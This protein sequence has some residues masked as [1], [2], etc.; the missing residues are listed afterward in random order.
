[1][2]RKLSTFIAL[3][4]L[5]AFAEGQGRGA[6]GNNDD[7]AK[8]SCEP[9]RCKKACEFGYRVENGCEVCA[10]KSSPM[11][12]DVTNCPA[13]DVCDNQC[14]HGFMLDEQGCTTCKCKTACPPICRMACRHGFEKDENGCDICTC[15][16]SAFNRT[17]H[18]GERQWNKTHHHN[19]NNGNKDHHRSKMGHRGEH[20]TRPSHSKPR[21]QDRN[22][23]HN[24]HKAGRHGGSSEVKCKPRKCSNRCVLGFAKDAFGCRTCTCNQAGRPAISNVPAP[25]TDQCGIRPMC[26][27]QCEFGFQKGS[28]GCAICRCNDA[29]TTS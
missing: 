9:V 21:H 1:M 5:V 24:N 22:E 11:A 25:A 3:F 28:D 10:C 17:H 13:I 7:S 26:L 4:A 19:Q 18:G 23:Q 29:S 15:R 8:G 14:P 20:V 2:I 16:T 27:M 6:H 12:A